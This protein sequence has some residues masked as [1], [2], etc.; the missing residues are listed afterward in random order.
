MQDLTPYSLGH[1]RISAGTVEDFLSFIG[2]SISRKKKSY[3]IP[4]NCTKYAVSKRDSKLR[5]VIN[6]ADLC[7]ADGKPIVWLSRRLGYRNVSHV[8]GIRLAEAVLARSRKENWRIFILGASPQNLEK[9]L[10]TINKRFNNPLIAGFCHG[11][12]NSSES[13]SEL[14]TERADESSVKTVATLAT[15]AFSPDMNC[16]SKTRHPR[17]AGF[18]PESSFP[19]V[20]SNPLLNEL[21]AVIESINACNPDILLLGLGM[22]QKEYF[23]HD[24]FHEINATFWLP[25]GG[26]IDIWARAKR[27]APLFLQQTGL[28]WLF[29]SFSNKSKALNILKYSL[30]FTRDFLTHSRP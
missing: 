15:G 1:I 19:S 29:R 6:S 17:I 23:I 20:L 12:F 26:A 25:V 16:G 10:H 5:E 3:C 22:P 9:A 30:S 24:H 13:C 11:Y 27:R 28:E 4:L 18:I 14:F 7:L 21:E 8:T 2:K